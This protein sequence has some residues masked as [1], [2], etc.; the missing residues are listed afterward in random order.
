MEFVETM[1][2]H[3]A[4]GFGW[5]LVVQCARGLS[6]N[7]E[8][9]TVL[10]ISLDEDDVGVGKIEVPLAVPQRQKQSWLIKIW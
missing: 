5:G 9:P 7:R 2:E 3:S 4:I 1:T 10:H 8:A 6:V